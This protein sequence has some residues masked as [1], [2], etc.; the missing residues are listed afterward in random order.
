MS[1]E[2][3]F[4]VSELSSKIQFICLTGCQCLSYTSNAVTMTKALGEE[5]VFST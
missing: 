3:L 1:R 2:A 5:R 4:Y